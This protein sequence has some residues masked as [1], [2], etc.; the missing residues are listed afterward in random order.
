MNFTSVNCLQVAV[1]HIMLN[2]LRLHLIH[3][4]NNHFVTTSAY[5]MWEEY[6]FIPLTENKLTKLK[7]G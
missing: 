5:V 3:L 2:E 6:F 1:S 4:V 7:G